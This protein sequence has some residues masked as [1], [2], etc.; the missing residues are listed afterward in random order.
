MLMCMYFVFM[1]FH[2]GRLYIHTKTGHVLWLVFWFPNGFMPS[3]LAPSTM[4]LAS[5]AKNRYSALNALH[6]LAST[7]HLSFGSSPSSGFFLSACQRMSFASLESTKYRCR[8][9]VI[10]KY[11]L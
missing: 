8:R 2:G 6:W 9:G 5:S 11:L 10:G 3:V 4:F 7:R 1:H